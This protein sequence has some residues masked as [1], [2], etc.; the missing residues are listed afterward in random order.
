MN[1]RQHFKVIGLYS[2]DLSVIAIGLDLKST[3]DS[4]KPIAKQSNSIDTTNEDILEQYSSG[5]GVENS[6]M[7]ATIPQPLS[8]HPRQRSEPSASA[9]H[10]SPSE[11]SEKIPDESLYS[12]LNAP[13]PKLNASS[14]AS[15]DSGLYNEDG[16]TV[17][18]PSGGSAQAEINFPATSRVTVDMPFE[19]FQKVMA[20][21]SML[22]ELPAISSDIWP[23]IERVEIGYAVPPTESQ[24]FDIHRLIDSNS[25]GKSS[26]NNLQGTYR[27]H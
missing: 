24:Y 12:A 14:M 1:Q 10:H 25:I 26:V 21:L 16:L 17:L 8:T 19:L 7:L 20:T 18:V 9:K 23:V 22:H 2:F 4:Q 5:L 27:D 13:S 15:W 6:A 11:S 3:S